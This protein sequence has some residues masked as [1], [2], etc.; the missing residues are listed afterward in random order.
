[1]NFVIHNFI[2]IKRVRNPAGKPK[3][4]AVYMCRRHIALNGLT[5]QL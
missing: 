3:T 1:M 5:L 2:V 4:V